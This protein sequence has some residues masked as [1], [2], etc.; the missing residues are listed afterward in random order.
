[1][2]MMK[3]ESLEDFDARLQRLYAEPPAPTHCRDMTPAQLEAFERQ[4]G[5]NGFPAPPLYSPPALPTE[6]RFRAAPADAV[7]AGHAL[8][9]SQTEADAWARA[10]GIFCMLRR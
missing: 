4:H 1:M 2:P 10:N 9:W 6:R 5:L 3:G 8:D 7:P